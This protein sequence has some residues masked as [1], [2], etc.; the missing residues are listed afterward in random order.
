M[1]KI[2]RND[3]VQVLGAC[4]LWMGMAYGLRLIGIAFGAI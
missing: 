1:K 3:F 4:A 2:L